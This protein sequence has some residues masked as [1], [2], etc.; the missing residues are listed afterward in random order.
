MVI[1][2]ILDRVGELSLAMS[3]GNDVYLKL[4]PLAHRFLEN[5]LIQLIQ[6]DVQFKPLA[7]T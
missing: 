6:I 7:S 4:F 5:I 3:D 1:R 2:N